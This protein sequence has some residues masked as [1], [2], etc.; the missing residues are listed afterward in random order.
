MTLHVLHEIS[1][2]SDSFLTPALLLCFSHLRIAFRT[3]VLLFALR[4]AFRTHVLLF[5][6]VHCFSHLCIALRTHALF[7]R[8]YASLFAFPFAL[9]HGLM[10]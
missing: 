9:M 6:L 1:I 4:I 7:F 10:F 5:A 8:T 2:V 3:H